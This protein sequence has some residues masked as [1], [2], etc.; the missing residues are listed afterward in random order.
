MFLLELVATN[1]S[2]SQGSYVSN[3][4]PSILMFGLKGF[5]MSASGVIQGHHDPLVIVSGKSWDFSHLI[6]D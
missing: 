5:Y 1:L 6:F 4:F 2:P 3:H